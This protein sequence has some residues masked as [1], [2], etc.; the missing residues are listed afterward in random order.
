MFQRHFFPILLAFGLFRAFLA[1]SVQ[2]QATGT[3]TGYVFD[4]ESGDPLPGA[5]VVVEGTALGVSTDRLGYFRLRNVP[6]GRQTLIV[7][8]IGFKSVETTVEVPTGGTVEYTFELVGDVLEAEGLL[9]IGQALSQQR[10]IDFKRSTRAIVAAAVQDDIGN[11]P[12]LNTAAAIRRLPGVSVQNDQSEPR[13]AVVRGL[14]PTYN[15]TSLDGGFLASPERGSFGRAVPLDV[16]PASLLAR[17]EVYKTVTPDM[18]HNAIGGVINMV[19]RSAFEQETPFLYGQFYGGWH[20]QSGEGGTLDGDERIQPL[21]GNIAGGLRFGPGDAFGVVA[22]IDYSVRNF[23]I[24]QVEVDDA[25]YTEFDA[26]GN[27]VGLGN[28]NGI[29]VP[30]NQRIFWYNNVRE[31]I[32]SHAKLEWRPSDRLRAELAGA[33]VVFNDDERRDEHRYELGTNESAGEPAV[34]RN[35]SATTGVTDTGFGIVGLGRFTL[36]RQI[37]SV[38][39]NVEYI[40]APAL[41]VQARGAYSGAELNNPESTEAFQTDTGFGALFDISDFF[42]TYSPLDPAGFYDPSNYAFVSRG[43]LDR[44]VNDEVTEVAADVVWVPERISAPVEV[45]TGGLY[46]SRTKEEGFDF[47]R[48]TTDL[49]YTL[50]DVVD[51]RLADETWQGG[52]KMPFRVGS[53]AA[54]DYFERNRSAFTQAAASASRSRAAET[55]IAAYGM[56]TVEFSP[57]TII[58]GLR[59]EG[60]RWNG[61]NLLEDN[62][63]D[64][65]YD[66]LLFDMQVNWEALDDLRLRGAFTQTLGRPNLS[67]LTRGQS[68]DEANRTISGSNPDLKPRTSNNLDL[69]I[70]WYAP[71]GLLAAGLFYKDIR[72]EIFNVT[73]DISQTIGGTTFTR[74]VGP[75]NAQDAS[76]LGLELQY[77]Q[78]L[79]FLPAPWDKL[80]IAGNATFLEGTLNVPLSNGETRE[81]GLYQQPDRTYNLMGF[82]AGDR[83]EVRLSYNWTD[84][85]IDLVNPDNPD[86][87]EYWAAR[88]QIDVQLRVNVTDRVSLLLEG[89][90]LTNAG[91]T[92]I[93]GPHRR[94]LQEDASFGRTFW[95]GLNASL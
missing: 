32:G 65:R 22:S 19:T 87:D 17:L 60:T 10:A 68:L 58:G 2:A 59:W 64:G 40:L 6:A 18:D 9:V 11:L 1:G 33:Y 24:P 51:R 28:G 71:E 35:Q 12:D 55:V 86:R 62:F 39:G 20:E 45:K 4:A 80:G 89:I 77:Q 16:I 34:I 15:H 52:Y 7:S 8:F 73:T 70:E 63:V 76:L 94:F 75:K 29:V 46:R 13:F 91:R 50:A 69:S 37:T 47:F 78:R 82:Y 95:L 56:A 85:F 3:I 79:F 43:E 21:R 27:N 49:D 26:A 30:T 84:E 66:N 53:A 67:D 38:R 74:F 81:I 93:T 83:F 61:G 5:N 41:R 31:R 48:Y 72:N 88:E 44:F 54:N 23:E 57:V 25:D 14:N 42:N 90:N 36:D 92:E